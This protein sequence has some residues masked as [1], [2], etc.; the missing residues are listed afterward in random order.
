MTGFPPKV[1]DLV[2][3][4]ADGRCERCGMF[5]DAMQLHHRRARGMGGST[6]VDTNTAANA[7]ALCVNCHRDV[8]S[9]RVDSVNL[10]FLVR[11][12]FD[13]A[14]VPVFR[15]GQWSLLGLGGDF[16]PATPAMHPTFDRDSDA[17]RFALSRRCGCCGA[18]PGNDCRQLDGKPLAA[19]Q[20]VHRDRA[21]RGV[22]AQ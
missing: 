7:L 16:T 8:E 13:P 4:R 21:E 15:R 14:A 18:K 10:G 12:G 19:G 2:L 6:A 5:T 9:M 20:V 1:R 3:R 11:Q 22:V 17:T